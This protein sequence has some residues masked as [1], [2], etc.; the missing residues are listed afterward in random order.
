MHVYGVD[1][2]QLQRMNYAE[3]RALADRLRNSK[4]AKLAKLVGAFRMFGDAERRRRIKHAPS[5]VHDVTMGNDLLK[6]LPGELTNLAI[7]E[8]EEQFW[9]RWAKGGL[10]QKEVRGPERAGQ[11]P[12]IFVCDESGSMSSALDAS[13]NSCEAWSKAVALSLCDQARRDKRDFTYIGFA[14]GGEQWE[15]TFPGGK[16]TVEG[17]MEFTEHFFGGGT[18]YTKPLGRAMEIIADYEKRSKVKPDIVFVT[19]ADCQVPQEFKDAWNEL[20]KRADVKCFGIQIGGSGYYNDMKDLVDRCIT[21][22]RENANPAG[23]KELFRGI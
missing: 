10:L 11:G 8:L 19:D 13:G 1:K 2:G 20:K 16:T 22:G 15:T 3:R 9:L 18:E 7:P 4:L 12:I 23:I 14:S 17:V 6:L 5:E 21:I